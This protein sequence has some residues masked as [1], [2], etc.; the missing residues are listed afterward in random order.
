ME[1]GDRV[2]AT[3]GLRGRRIIPLNSVV[4]VDRV[5]QTCHERVRKPG[6]EHIV[7]GGRLGSGRI[8]SGRHGS[9]IYRRHRSTRDDDLRRRAPQRL[10]PKRR[11]ADADDEVGASVANPQILRELRA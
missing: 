10:G 11:M 2:A 4:R 6:V 3:R 7:H 5:V 8:Y 1:P 9:V